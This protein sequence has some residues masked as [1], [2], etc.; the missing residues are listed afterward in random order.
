MTH[1]SMAHKRFYCDYTYW[2]CADDLDISSFA[3]DKEN[4]WSFVVNDTWL[5]DDTSV[6]DSMFF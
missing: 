1:S 2:I 4:V 3:F 6:D 5:G